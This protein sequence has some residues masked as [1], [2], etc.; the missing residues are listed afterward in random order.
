MSQIFK[1]PNGTELPIMDLRGKPYLLVAHRLVWFRE[2]HPDWSIQ[3]EFLE[4]SV[5]QSFAKAVI[6]KP[7]GQIMSTAHKFE[8]KQGFSDHREKAE[9]GAIGRALA[10]IGFGTQFCADDLDEG[11]RIV[12]APVARSAVI[13]PPHPG[14]GNGSTAERPGVIRYGYHSR[15][16]PSEVS[17][18]ELE[19][20][21]DRL[22]A[23]PGTEAHQAHLVIEEYLRLSD[24]A[25]EPFEAPNQDA[26]I[27]D[28]GE[29]EVPFGRKYKGRKIKDI[30][31]QEIE[32]YVAWLEADSAKKRQ[33]LGFETTLLKRA[34]ELFY[35]AAS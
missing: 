13:R 23:V 6:T 31:R 11:A 32:S 22:A 4:Q 10:L 9:T 20:E 1:T 5:A 19:I 3:T 25:P 26:P 8:D 16:H 35:G 2:V 18:D 29:F 15:K 7:D 12:D 21:R 27:G 24:A 30:S 33:P 28:P 34:V 17:R 14:V